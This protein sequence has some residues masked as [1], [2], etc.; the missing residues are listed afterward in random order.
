MNCQSCGKPIERFECRT[1][2]N[3][4]FDDGSW[5]RDVEITGVTAHCQHD[6]CRHR[7]DVEDHRE[8]P[9][10]VYNDDPTVCL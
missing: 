9:A 3:Y 10:E 2:F 7:Q 5:M 8:L 4:Y 1:E 6:G